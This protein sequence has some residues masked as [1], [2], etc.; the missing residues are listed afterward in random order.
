MGEDLYG[1]TVVIQLTIKNCGL[2]IK[3]GV[4][5]GFDYLGD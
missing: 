4:K 2:T 5:L 3:N 1:K